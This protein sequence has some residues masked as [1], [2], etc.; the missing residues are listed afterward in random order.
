MAAD[1][2]S[3]WARNPNP[4]AISTGGGQPNESEICSNL[5]GTVSAGDGE[6]TS[7][8]LSWEVL[9]GADYRLADRVTLGVRAR[10]I[11]F[12]VL[13]STELAWDPLRSHAPN[14]RLDG[15]EPVHGTIRTSELQAVA[16]S[17]IMR[18]HL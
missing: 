11:D 6:L 10:R 4:D 16:L 1:Y 12:P 9:L 7:T 2:A 18:Y 3:R 8:G 14:L 17:M 5:A 15:S 13:E